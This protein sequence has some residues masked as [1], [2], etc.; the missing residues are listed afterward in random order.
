[1]V[2][3]QIV[4]HL[5]LEHIPQAVWLDHQLGWWYPIYM[6]H[7]GMLVLFPVLCSKESDIY[8]PGLSWR[9]PVLGGSKSAILGQ[10]GP[11]VNRF[12]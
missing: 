10:I 4:T 12:F 7:S 8:M 6:F 3:Y 9:G 11:S 1:M 2:K 5:R